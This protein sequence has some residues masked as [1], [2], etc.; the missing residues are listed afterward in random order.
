MKEKLFENIGGNSF[1]IASPQPMS[2]MAEDGEMSSG[3]IAD[4]ENGRPMVGTRPKSMEASSGGNQILAGYMSDQGESRKFQS[5]DE[6]DAQNM[7]VEPVY[8]IISGGKI[9]KYIRANGN[10]PLTTKDMKYF[11]PNGTEQANVLD[12]KMSR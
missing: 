8:A 5:G 12:K 2:M 1:K 7:L 3:D 6:F 4:Y 11:I 9:V 10:I